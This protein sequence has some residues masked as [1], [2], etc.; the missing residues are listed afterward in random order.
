MI[1]FNIFGERWHSAWFD[2][3]P[4]KLMSI[5]FLRQNQARCTLKYCVFVLMSEFA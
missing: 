4:R 2:L 5:V 1:V 3:S